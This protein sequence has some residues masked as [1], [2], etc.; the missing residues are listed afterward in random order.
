M[1]ERR[2]LHVV[3]Q[4]GAPSETFL[5]DRMTELERLGWEAWVATRGL[6]PNA[7]IELPRKRIVMPR[8]RR[9]LLGALRRGSRGPADSWVERGVQAVRPRLIHAHFGWNGLAVL[10]VARERRLP[11]VCGLHGYDVT[12]YPRYRFEPPSGHAPAAQHDPLVYRELFEQAA[13]VLVVSGFLAGRLRQLGYEHPVEVIPSGIRMSD[14]PFRGPREEPADCRLIFIGRLVPYKGLD[15]ALRALD[16]LPPALRSAR[17]E[18]IGE[19][20]LR[21]EHE[22][23][24][25]ELGLSERVT[26]RGA[27]PREE[28]RVALA[29]A[30]ILLAP[31]RTTASGQAE[32]LGNT[33]KEAYSVGLEVIASRSG[34]LPEVTPPS[35]H[36]E[37]VP[38]GDPDAL[39]AAIEARWD[40]RSR[41]AQ[42]ATDA[43]RWVAEAF[44]WSVLAPRIASIYERVAG[45]GPR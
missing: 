15:V 41:W 3:E 39:A 1:S 11:L 34:G 4:L 40:A 21:A 24:T 18:V 42:R 25:H 5:A 36:H 10:P 8:R 45:G 35:R 28:V 7:A 43:R 17:L 31:S 33:V 12:V 32:G 26:F 13:A 23:L 37:L 6:A 16:R 30:D 9:E 14:F 29:R 38:E 19:G 44:D 20:P 22:R 27:L 2:V